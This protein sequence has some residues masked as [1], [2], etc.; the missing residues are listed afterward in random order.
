M[1]GSDVNDE[2]RQEYGQ[3]LH[4]DQ[5]GRTQEFLPLGKTKGAAGQ[6][7]RRGLAVRGRS[8]G[9]KDG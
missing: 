1:S 3:V 6:G 9:G 7:T 8:K 4:R 5:G 2:K